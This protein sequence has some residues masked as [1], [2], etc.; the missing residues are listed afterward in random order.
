MN[1]KQINIVVIDDL[2]WFWKLIKR[3]FSM[4]FISRFVVIFCK[5]FTPFDPIP[6]CGDFLAKLM[7]RR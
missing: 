1:I 6:A 5:Y 3:K 7:E 4:I 2:L